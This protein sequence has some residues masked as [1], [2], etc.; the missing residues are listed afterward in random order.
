MRRTGVFLLAIAWSALLLPWERC[1][2]ACHDRLLPAVGEHRCHSDA[3]GD[4]CGVPGQESE[5]DDFNFDSSQPD[6]RV[7]LTPPAAA[8]DAPAFP[9]DAGAERSAHAEERRSPPRTTV[10]LL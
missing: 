4:C 10:L 8:P 2:A 5:H 6:G 3:D 9:S 1:H 7:A